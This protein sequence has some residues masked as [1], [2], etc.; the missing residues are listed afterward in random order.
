[1]YAYMCGDPKNLKHRDQS[2]ELPNDDYII[3]VAHERNFFI[4]AWRHKENIRRKRE[5]E[6]LL[7]PYKIKA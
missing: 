3:Q 2:Y 6:M 7:L 4:I 1:M 5:I